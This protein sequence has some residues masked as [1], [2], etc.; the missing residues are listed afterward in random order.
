MGSASS[1]PLTAGLQFHSRFSTR[2]ST[3]SATTATTHFGGGV[4]KLTTKQC[5]TIEAIPLDDPGRVLKPKERARGWLL[6]MTKRSELLE[7]P[8]FVVGFQLSAMIDCGATHNF[9]AR[10]LAE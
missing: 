1:R 7:L 6:A 4:F 2:I 8:V 3:T 5:N 10:G 9:I